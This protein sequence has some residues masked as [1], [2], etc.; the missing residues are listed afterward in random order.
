MVALLVRAYAVIFT[1]KSF[2]SPHINLGTGFIQHNAHFTR[3]GNRHGSKHKITQKEV[4]SSSQSFLPFT[5]KN[6][7]NKK[8]KAEGSAEHKHVVRGQLLKLAV[9][10]AQRNYL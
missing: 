4:K 9:L 5:F 6:V 7:F 8:I 3:Y 10:T 1:L 2:I